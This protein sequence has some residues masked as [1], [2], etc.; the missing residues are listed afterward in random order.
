MRRVSGNTLLMMFIALLLALGTARIIRALSA[1]TSI[2]VH[3]HAAISHPALLGGTQQTTYI[4]VDLTGFEMEQLGDRT[5]V[6]IALVLDKSGSMNGQKMQQ[7]K[8]AAILAID[9]LSPG[10]VVSVISY[11]NTARVL[12]P[13]TEVGDKH[14]I[15]ER[16]RSLQAQGGTAL[17]AGVSEG[18]QELR[19]FL[20]A[21][22]VN[23]VILLSDGQA[24][25][26]P[27][28][29]TEL[30]DL[31]ASLIKEGISVTTIGLGL[32]YNEDLMAQLA[33]RSDGNH[34]FVEHVDELARI[35]N[36][37]FGDV[38][39]VVAQNVTVTIDCNEGIRPVRV[40][41]RDAEIDGQQVVVA[42][43]QL[44]SKQDKYIVLEVETQPAARR[45]A[46]EIAR[47]TTS[48]AN[49][50]THTTDVLT[51]TI[52]AQIT[53]SEEVVKRNIDKEAMVATIEQQGILNEERAIFLRDQGR[54]EEAERMLQDNAAF[55]EAN[56]AL[57][58]ADTLYFG[59]RKSLEA[60][61]N[62]DDARWNQQRKM[63]RSDH[64]RAKT[65]QSY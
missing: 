29:P 27:S 64:Y 26:G 12:V 55:L 23:R 30:G 49:M 13:A 61:A 15:R 10:D 18:A 62:L 4:K 8:E 32:Q 38:L 50:L 42:L 21:N 24:N 47:V 17:F 40:L 14:A 52:S 35:F 7:A 51:S 19:R 60:A 57:Y 33:R 59:A 3:L 37:E 20:D 43:N 45:G 34:S 11:D 48:Y 22:R 44:Y 39:S 63:L 16:I 56:A 53:D 28:T 1:G 9:R 25:E 6:N 46:L 54:R 65:Q 58:G 36:Q 5:P 41:G 31:G 2:Q